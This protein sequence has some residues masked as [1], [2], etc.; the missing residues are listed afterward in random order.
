MCAHIF[1]I[2]KKIKQRLSMTGEIYEIPRKI[3]TIVNTKILIGH[4]II[5][6][7]NNSIKKRMQ[8]RSS[9]NNLLS[10]RIN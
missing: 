3:G 2:T 9:M 7:I 1:Q 8:N 5:F 6:N 10:W 4:E